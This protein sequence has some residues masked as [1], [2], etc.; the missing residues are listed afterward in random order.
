MGLFSFSSGA[1][2]LPWTSIESVD[3]LHEVLENSGDKPALLF[4]HSTRCSISAM[5]L[6]AFERQWS[7][8]N[9]RCQL[10]FVDLIRNRD[11]SNEIASATGVTHQSPQ[12]ILWNG[13]EVLYNASH[14]G[15][16]ANAVEKLLENA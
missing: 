5:A 4:K 1:K 11:V 16:D 12:A 8:E 15:I 3:Q 14:S 13:K 9:E 6:N 7:S 2:K 10:Y